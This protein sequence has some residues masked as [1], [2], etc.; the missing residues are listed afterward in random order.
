MLTQ[1]EGKENCLWQV[2][3]LGTSRWRSAV[4]GFTSCT[5]FGGFGDI[6]VF[7]RKHRHY[8]ACDARAVS[9]DLVS[10][11]AVWILWTSCTGKFLSSLQSLLAGRCQ[12]KKTERMK[13]KKKRRCRDGNGALRNAPLCLKGHSN[14]VIMS[15]ND[16]S[17]SFQARVDLNKSEYPCST[18]PYLPFW[19]I[20]HMLL[21]QFKIKHKSPYYT[22]EK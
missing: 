5:F 1:W 15:E 22:A 3:T 9:S 21:L 13:R 17:C 10:P 8:Q 12:L 18:L 2:L 20:F 4:P 16:N 19:L 7:L 6:L 14:N 11:A